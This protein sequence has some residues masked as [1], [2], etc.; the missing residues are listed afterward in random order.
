MRTLLSR[1]RLR[2][3]F[4]NNHP[5]L[6]LLITSKGFRLCFLLC[7]LIFAGTPLC[8]L[9]LFQTSEGE[10]GPVIKISALDWLQGESLARRA[11]NAVLAEDLDTAFHSWRA[12]IGNHPTKASFNREYLQALLKLD[13]KRSQWHDGLRTSHWLLHLSR[14]NQTALELATRTLEFYHLDNLN[15]RLIQSSP[16]ELSPEIEMSYLRSLFRTGQDGLFYRKLMATTSTVTNHPTLQCFKLAYEAATAPASSLN[17]KMEHLESVSLP[18]EFDGETRRLKLYIY[19]RQRKLPEF[20]QILT[21]LTDRFQ[22]QIA[23]HLL[24]WDLLQKMGETETAIRLAREFVLPPQTGYHVMEIADAYT[25]LGL[26]RHAFN[27]LKNYAGLFGSEDQHRY[28]QSMLLI[29]EKDWDG[30]KRFALDLRS[31]SGVA[32]S[33]LAY[34]YYL[35]GL[36]SYRQGRKWEASQTFKKI[37]TFPMESSQLAL[38]VGANLWDLGYS[39][40][41]Y[42]VLSPQSGLHERNAA[43]WRMMLEITASL[44]SGPRMLDAAEKLFQLAPHDQKNKINLASLLISERRQMDRAITLI[45]DALIQEPDNPIIK[46][47]YAQGLAL[48]GRITEAIKQ[49][50]SVDNGAFSVLQRQGYVFAWLAVL[51]AQSNASRA[52]QL[53]Q[54]IKPEL[55]LPGDRAYYET[56]VEWAENAQELASTN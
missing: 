52:L 42:D 39:K 20:Q 53:A 35:E 29:T 38:L 48:S 13:K 30:L 50:Q 8:I 43:F 28:A 27:Y 12:A 49:L 31:Q 34:S 10:T 36:G 26:N 56:I 32:N 14:T 23:D 6:S 45:F 15:L 40:E 1:R 11:R 18:S 37:S 3:Y 16:A 25:K 46:V 21:E 7:S 5:L 19:H 4:L 24:H 22:N 41:A 17:E 54:E 51:H 44:N 9:K 47:N 55:L 33:F 2:T